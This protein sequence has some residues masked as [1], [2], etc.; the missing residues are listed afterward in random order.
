M[1]DA[2]ALLDVAREMADALYEV[3]AMDDASFGV[4]ERLC[5]SSDS[6]FTLEDIHHI[7]MVLHVNRDKFSSIQ[8]TGATSIK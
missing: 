8:G 1:T 2:S 5:H 7:Q 3:G 6:S 4:I